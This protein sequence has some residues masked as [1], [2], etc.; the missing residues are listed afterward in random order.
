MG[1]FYNGVESQTSSGKTCQH[2]TETSPHNPNAA[3]KNPANFPDDS[4][5]DASN[6][7]RNPDSTSAGPWCYTTDPGTRWQYCDVP[8]CARGRIN[9]TKAKF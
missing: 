8:L 7:C 3:S 6:Y 4:I 1:F 9:Q 5:A 2:W